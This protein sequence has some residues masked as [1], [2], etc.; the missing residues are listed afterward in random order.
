MK[1]KKSPKL[2][3][4]N[5]YEDIILTDEQ[6]KKVDEFFVKNYGK[7]IPYYCAFAKMRNIMWYFAC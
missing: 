7:K 2:K 4:K 1:L 3:R 5:L 6:K